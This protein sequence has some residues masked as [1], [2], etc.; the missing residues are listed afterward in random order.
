[1]DPDAWAPPTA[2]LRPRIT[3]THQEKNQ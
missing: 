3:S 2:D 1:V